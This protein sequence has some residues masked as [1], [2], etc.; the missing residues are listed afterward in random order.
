MT[1]PI[2]VELHREIMPNKS[3]IPE[4]SPVIGSIGSKGIC[5]SPTIRGLLLR[6]GKNSSI[7]FLLL[8]ATDGL[9]ATSAIHFFFGY[10]ARH[11]RTDELADSR[12]KVTIAGNKGS[13]SISQSSTHTC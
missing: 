8:A 1:F 13:R 3:W 11:S 6:M 12:A 4:G 10:R 9:R 5:V 7:Q 2:R